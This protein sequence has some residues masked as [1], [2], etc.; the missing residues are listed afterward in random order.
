MPDQGITDDRGEV[1]EAPDPNT[2]ADDK[3]T[4]R[5]D[6]LVCGTITR[7]TPG[8]Y[9]YIVSVPGRARLVCRQIDSALAKPLGVSGINVLLENTPVLVWVPASDSNYGFILGAVPSIVQGKQQIE[10]IRTSPL[11]MHLL[12]PESG[13]SLWSESAYNEPQSDSRNR[14]KLIA[15]NQ[16]LGDV[17]PGDWGKQNIYGVLMGIFGMI[18]TMRASDRAKI[19]VHI[20]DDLVRMVSNQ[21]QHLSSLGEMHIYND[22]GLVSFEF[23][24]SGHDLEVAGT[25][26]YTE[27]GV[28]A[29]QERDDQYL[30]AD[31]KLR[32]EGQ[33]V[34]RRCQLFVGAM[35]DLFQLFIA[36]PP[37]GQETYEKE[38]VLQGLLHAQLDSSGAFRLSAANGVSLRRRDRIPV[39]KKIKEPWDPSGARPEDEDFELEEK[40]PYEYDDEHPFARNLQLY[41]GDEWLLGQA[42]R[43]FDKLDGDWYTPENTDMPVPDD[44][45]DKIGKATE[46]FNKYDGRQAGVFVEADGSVVIRDAWGSEIYMRGGNM[47]ISC[48]GDCMMQTGGSVVQLG[49]RD[50]VIKGRKSVDVTATENDVRLKAQNNLH[51]YSAEGGIL[52][53]TDSDGSG[54]G[55]SAGSEGEDV[56]SNGITLKASNSRVFLW[57]SIVHLASSA[58]MFIESIGESLGQIIM[59]AGRILQNATN[60]SMVGSEGKSSLVLGGT[61]QLSGASVA[62]QATGSVGIYRADRVLI[63]LSW[64]E[65]DTNPAERALDAAL[66]QYDTYV[67]QD[68]WLGAYNESGR[69]PIM[70]TFRTDVQYGTDTATETDPEATD[71][72]I[73][74]TPWQFLADQGYELISGEVESW[75]EVEVNDTYPWPGRENYRRSVYITL[76]GLANFENNQP[77]SRSALTN[78]PRGFE[79]KSLD[80]Y[81]ILR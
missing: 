3:Q 19:E 12:N 7:A 20:L 62:V 5:T 11:L 72:Q 81:P 4:V 63:P 50:V 66:R 46:N 45:Y 73:Y 40:Q 48:P 1:E 30:Q 77:K 37:D 41:D 53:E 60:I 49:G 44:E 18:A 27:D 16:R 17:L 51:A 61:A 57:G 52:L 69:D 64:E 8:T 34:K 56:G 21:F 43:I 6:F 80:D 24:G 78:E 23:A 13:A 2:E 36:K 79:P 29:E 65:I 9:D 32:E 67:A 15:N 74:Q 10:K 25:D 59:S 14:D 31:F 35:A 22:G 71:F 68:G 55:F 39:P 28:F 26:E 70:F 58:R 42:Y 38:S 76:D 75:Q 54:H 47:V 33:T